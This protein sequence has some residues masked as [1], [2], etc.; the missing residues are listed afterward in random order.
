MADLQA[1]AERISPYVHRTPV[2]TCSTFDQWCDAELYFKCENLQ[3]VGA[4]KIRGATN[5]VFSL[6]DAEAARGVATHS[7]GNHAAALA[8]AAR[9]RGIAAHVVM[10]E[11]APA[12]KR[13]AVVGYGARV[14]PCAPTLAAREARLTE[15]VCQTGAAVVHPYN[16]YGVIAGQATA[17][18]E[19]L[20]AFPNLDVV[21]TPVGGGGL[22]SGAAL[23]AHYASPRTRVIAA[24]PERADDAYRSLQA[25]RIIPLE[26]T[27]TVADGLRTSLGDLTF[28]II[29]QHV[30]A[31]VRV[32][33][34]AIISTTRLVWE[35]MK[36]IVEP[37][38]VLPLAALLSHA[39]DLRGQRI[40]I[41]FSGGN[42]DLA[43]LPWRA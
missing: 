24:E 8:L 28:S 4:F 3:K 29:Q 20:D 21:M 13:A 36:L 19:L 35:R 30:T 26:H 42:V 14:Y 39:I 43:N 15:V 38:G 10:P 2:F 40:G 33:E 22:L 41:I 7:S 31:I 11:N 9:L 1:A 34:D 17:T 32:S 23:A 12:V 27:D 5:A 6:S 16:D 25:G 37:S 18:M